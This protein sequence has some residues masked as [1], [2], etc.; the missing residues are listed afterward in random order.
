MWQHTNNAESLQK[1][2]IVDDEINVCMGC[3]R[4]LDEEGYISNYALSGT[5]GLKKAENDN[6]DMIITDMRMPDISGMEVIKQI[7]QKR[8]YIPVVMITGY[9]T[10]SY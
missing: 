5:E 9:L 10:F 2:L 3:K 1:I 7:K 6:F 8:P 4:L